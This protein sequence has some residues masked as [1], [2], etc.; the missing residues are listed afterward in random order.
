MCDRRWAHT[1]VHGR[2]SEDNDLDC[3]VVTFVL[4][5][6]SESLYSSLRSLTFF[7]TLFLIQNMDSLHHI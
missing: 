1:T 4:P 5:K 3:L 7:F 2:R 6:V